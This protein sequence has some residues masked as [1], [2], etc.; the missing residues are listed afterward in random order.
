MADLPIDI[1][2]NTNPP[3]FRWTQLVET[4]SGRQVV[5]YIETLPPTLEVAVQRLILVAK[6]LLME[7][8]GLRG[9]VESLHDRVRPSQGTAQPIKTKA[10]G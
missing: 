8:A 9:Q 1:I 10:K 4:M 7:N 2:P 6:Q 3:Q 5:E